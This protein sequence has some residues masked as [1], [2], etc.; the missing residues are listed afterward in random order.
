MG[1][2]NPMTFGFIFSII[3]WAILFI[4]ASFPTPLK[5]GLLF[6]LF[7]SGMVYFLEH[8]LMY[9]CLKISKVPEDMHLYTLR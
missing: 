8:V 4:A 6:L 7:F 9:H 2:F 5:I 3:S 1:L